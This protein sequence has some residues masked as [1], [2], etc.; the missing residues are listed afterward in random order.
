VPSHPSLA[1][2]EQTQM[3]NGKVKSQPVDGLFWEL[4]D[5]VVAERDVL[6]SLVRE[7]SLRGNENLPRYRNPDNQEETWSGRGRRP[8]WLAAQLQAGKMLS[9]FMVRRT[10]TSDEL[11]KG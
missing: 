4:H 11:V 7:L 9:D 2:E 1:R 3:K 10:S 8:R 5:L 6:E